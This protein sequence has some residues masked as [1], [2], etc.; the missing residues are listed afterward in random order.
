MT[1]HNICTPRNL[2][3]QWRT[4]ARCAAIRQAKAADYAEALEKTHGHLWLSVLKPDENTE[5]AI[6]ALR[7]HMLRNT[8]APAGLWSIET[9]SKYAG[10]HL[11]LLTPGRPFTDRLMKT[12]W[13]AAI[14]T[15][16]RAAAAYITKQ[17]GA[18][19]ETQYNG[20]LYGTFGNMADILTR[21][22]MPLLISAAAIETIITPPQQRDINLG[23]N[24]RPTSPNNTKPKTPEDFKRIA[25]THLPHLWRLVLAKRAQDA[26][27][28]TDAKATV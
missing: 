7:A 28:D 21:Q 13:S 3:R 18:P 17:S 26:I 22:D 8:V 16:S 19:A 2:C 9:G 4:C 10:L 11:N 25:A 24:Q 15:T 6:R 20:R 1:L 14:N 12:T 5:H 27:S 23:R